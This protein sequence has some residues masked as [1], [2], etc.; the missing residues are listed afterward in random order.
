MCVTSGLPLL[1]T[2]DNFDKVLA[3]RN[4]IVGIRV[5]D[6]STFCQQKYLSKWQ[7]V[8]KAFN[9]LIV[10]YINTKYKLLCSSS[11]GQETENTTKAL[12]VTP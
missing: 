7:C 8:H 9:K 10:K 6:L 2:V 3:L 4:L 11:D 5:R 12:V 1:S